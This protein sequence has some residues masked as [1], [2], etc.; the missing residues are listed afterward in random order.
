MVQLEAQ[1]QPGLACPVSVQKTRQLANR[2]A[3]FP[4][5]LLAFGP[6]KTSFSRHNP[7]HCS[8]DSVRAVGGMY[9]P[10]IPSTCIL[11]GVYGT[12]TN[13]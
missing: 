9:L 7:T 8:S 13:I 4:S 12:V 10:L 11:Q 5:S 2:G 1:A 3:D 6:E